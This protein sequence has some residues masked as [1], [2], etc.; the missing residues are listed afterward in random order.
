MA[1]ARDLTGEAHKR[2]VSVVT[3]LALIDP[4][5]GE[6]TVHS[7]DRHPHDGSGKQENLQKKFL[8][9]FALICSTSSKGGETASAVCLEQG[10][11]TGTVLRLASNLGVSQDLI[12]RLHL[13]LGDLTAVASRVSSV[14]EKESE[15]LYKIIDLTQDK[16]RSLL[17]RLCKPK[18]QDQVE[19]AIKDLDEDDYPLEGTEG[20]NFRNWIRNLPIL[21]ALEPGTELSLLIPHVK[22]ASQAKWVYSEQIEALFCPSGEELPP[23]INCIYKLGR[24]FAAAKAMLKLATAQRTIFEMIHVETVAAPEQQYFPPSKDKHALMAVLKRLLPKADHQKLMLQLG[25]TWLTSDPEQ[26]FRKACRLTL[27]VHAEMQLLTFYDHHPE[28]TPR[29]FY[30]GT[31]KKACFLCDKYISQHPL[32]MSV[33]ASHQKLYPS[34][35]PAP[36]SESSVRKAHKVRLWELSRQLEQTTARDLETRLGIRRPKSLDST[37]GPSLT[38]MDSLTSGWLLAQLAIHPQPQGTSTP[39]DESSESE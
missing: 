23:W 6:P 16:I 2:F 4:V 35:M 38:S 3:L 25:Q 28:F 27:T 24:Y 21:T 10:G 13:V 37:A 33:S 18:I 1:Q 15:I 8:D 34:W 11:P 12:D 29:L 36:C 32:R 39:N 22:W 5:R 19:V 17:A 7:L 30:M 26:R 14:R 20:T 9:S 31:S